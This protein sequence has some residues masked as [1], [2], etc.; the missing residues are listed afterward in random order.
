[1]DDVVSTAIKVFAQDTGG[2]T[3]KDNELPDKKKYDRSTNIINRKNL[4]I[5]KGEKVLNEAGKGLLREL[6][7][8]ADQ[9]INTEIHLDEKQPFGSRSEW[10][11]FSDITPYSDTVFAQQVGVSYVLILKDLY[12]MHNLSIFVWFNSNATISSIFGVY[13]LCKEK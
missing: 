5:T 7:I 12:F 4:S 8:I 10:D 3:Y 11:D 1:M 2:V 9:E 13:D 6:V